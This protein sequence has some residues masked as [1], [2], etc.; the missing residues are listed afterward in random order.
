MNYKIITDSDKLIEFINWLPELEKGETFYC[1]LLARSK[2]GDGS[3]KL[4][5]DKQQLKRFTST[6]EYLY[7]KIKQL[8]C[9][10]GS[11]KQK[12][13]GIPNDCLAVYIHPNPRSLEKAAKT[14]LKELVDLVIKPYT[15]YN[16]HQE[17]LSAIQKSCSRTVYYDFDFDNGDI[18]IV[19]QL[20]VD[21]IN[22]NAYSIVKTRGGFHVLLEI[23]KIDK[24]YNKGWFN[25]FSNLPG[26]DKANKGDLMLPIPGTCQGGFT[27]H[28]I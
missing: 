21:K 13:L 16:P 5:S 15:G 9:E 12:G 2:Y 25:T 7:D 23:N 24:Q 6:K 4:S 3:V 27:P 10:V 28:F 20:L 18:D 11:Y 19:K 22:D 14:A 8:E 17:V 26:L 1:T